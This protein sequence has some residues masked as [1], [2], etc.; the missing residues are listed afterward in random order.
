MSDSTKDGSKPPLMDKEKE[1]KK[2][3]D[4]W[5]NSF[6]SLFS[7]ATDEEIALKEHKRC[8][9]WKKSLIKNNSLIEF[10]LENL[11]KSGCEFDVEK[12]FKCVPCDFKRSG[13]FSPELG[14]ILC[15]NRFSSKRHLQ[16]T[17]THEMIHAFDQCTTKVNF[18][19]CEQHACAE[20]RAINLSGECKFLTEVKRGNFGFASHHQKCVKRRALITL[21]DLDCCKGENVAEDALLHVW[22][23]CFNDKAPF[24]EIY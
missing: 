4:N 24:D 16:D 14:I 11:K 1:E 17:L 19:N 18:N 22:K 23:S 20:I 13:G 21:K 9:K 3:L 5:T 12:H 7:G 6:K 10:M 15:Q 8:E 2:L